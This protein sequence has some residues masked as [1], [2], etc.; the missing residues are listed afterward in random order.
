MIQA[1]RLAMVFDS[2]CAQVK[3]LRALSKT[4]INTKF[5][6]CNERLIKALLDVRIDEK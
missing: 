6:N 4:G 1:N 5:F 3:P 2:R